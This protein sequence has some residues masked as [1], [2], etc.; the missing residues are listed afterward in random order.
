MQRGLRALDRGRLAA[1][2]VCGPPLRRATAQA[3]LR[4][5]VAP[6]GVLPGDLCLRQRGLAL[7]GAAGQFGVALP[8][9]QRLERARQRG[10]RQKDAADESGSRPG[11]PDRADGHRGRG[12]S[13][14]GVGERR[15][16][17]AQLFA[18]RHRARVPASHHRR[19]V[20]AGVLEARPALALDDPRAGGAGQGASCSLSCLVCVG[21]GRRPSLRGDRARR[22]RAAASDSISWRGSLGPCAAN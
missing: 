6:G 17:A 14:V 4:P 1:R 22:A 12:G 13:D 20:R 3:A 8:A 11:H 9:H 18:Q 16:S 19:R 10:A 2:G 7:R 5:A 15:D 21:R